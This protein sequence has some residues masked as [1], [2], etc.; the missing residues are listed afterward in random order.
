M[1]LILYLLHNIFNTDYYNFIKKHLNFK[2]IFFYLILNFI[3][4]RKKKKTFFFLIFLIIN[5]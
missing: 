5:D 3:I 1:L 4:K 2:Y